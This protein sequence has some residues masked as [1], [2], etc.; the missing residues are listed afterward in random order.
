M[1]EKSSY[2]YI[3]VDKDNNV[4]ILVPITGGETVGTDN[5]C[6]AVS[7]SKYFVNG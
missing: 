3:K 2:S 5:T 7:A 1:Q 4:H 6:K